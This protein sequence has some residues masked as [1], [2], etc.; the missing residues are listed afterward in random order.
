MSQVW[1]ITGA[2]RGLGAAI[3]RAALDAGHRV[4][5]AVRNRAT[6]VADF[7]ICEVAAEG[8]P[9]VHFP[10]GSD[11][12]QWV[13]KKNPAVQADVERFRSLSIARAFGGT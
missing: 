11:A 2:N 6:T 4:V 5:A 8:A 1:F 9:P 12:I 13:E 7:G 3:A 10:V